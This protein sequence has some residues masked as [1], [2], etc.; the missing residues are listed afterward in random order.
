MLC[1]MKLTKNM[2][3]WLKEAEGSL[4]QAEEAARESG[5]IQVQNLYQIAPLIFSKRNSM[6]YAALIQEMMD[7]NEEQVQR[8]WACDEKSKE[9][10]KF[11]YISSYLFCFVVAKQVEETEYDEI[12]EYVNSKMELFNDDYDFE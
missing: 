2:K 1:I 7:E 8:D 12:M 6:N 4:E 11:H 5:D 3:Q 10:Y 9:Q